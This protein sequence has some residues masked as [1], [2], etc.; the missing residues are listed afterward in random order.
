MTDA[1]LESADAN[2]Y[3]DA[4][5]TAAPEFDTL[6]ARVTDAY[7]ALGY[8]AELISQWS[9]PRVDGA[10]LLDAVARA[11]PRNVLEVGTFVGVS[12]LL[13]ALRVGRGARIHTVDPNLPLSVEMGSMQSR[14][15]GCDLSIRA[16]DLGAPAARAL[17]V[18]DRITF[19]AGGF[20]SG[21]TFASNNDAATAPV[22]VVGPAVCAQHGPFDLAFVDG[23]HYED[24]VLADLEL[25]APHLASNGVLVLHDVIGM[26]G[27][28]VRRAAFRF[29]EA[30]P[31]F[32]LEHRPF[33]KLYESIGML[34]HA[35]GPRAPSPD[36]TPTI[37]Q[38]RAYTARLAAVVHNRLAPRRVLALGGPSA[39]LADAL[40][41]HGVECAT[42][43]GAGAFDLCLCLGALERVPPADAERLLDLCARSSDTILFASTPPGEF[44]ATHP[45]DRPIA[46]WVRALARRGFVFD[47]SI[48]PV[49]EPVSFANLPA[50]VVVRDDAELLGLY[51]LRRAPAPLDDATVDRLAAKEARIEDLALQGLFADLVIRRGIGDAATTRDRALGHD[52]LADDLRRQAREQTAVAEA[53]RAEARSLQAEVERQCA[54]GEALAAEAEDARRRTQELERRRDELERELARDEVRFGRALAER[55]PWFYRLLRRRLGM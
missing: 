10:L 51:L 29:L 30:H 26:W 43:P 16:Q 39:V 50:P 14:D 6:F 45:N 28:N 38:Q 19:H 52:A 1:L 24:A 12:T 49:L 15:F 41:V 34:R 31:E 36:R 37:L 35:P 21:A 5:V 27:S 32:V 54:R 4:R 46:A 13:M 20:S 3:H 47:D 44:G 22:P 33:A 7:A 17:G 11:A 53:L 55:W 8:P 42:D 25:C 23:L 48:R 40:R 18:D 9:L 2:R